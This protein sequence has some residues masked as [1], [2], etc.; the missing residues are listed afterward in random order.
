M[1]YKQ[2]RK[3]KKEEGKYKQIN[4]SAPSKWR[5]PAGVLGIILL[6]LVGLGYAMPA[7]WNASVGQTGLTFAQEPFRLG[8]DLL[9][10]THLVY[11]ADLSEIPE[12]ERRDSLR[13][14][15]D[16]IERRVNAFGVA[17]PLVQ[18]VGDD[19]IIV[20]LAGISDVNEAINQIG[21]TPIL[22]FKR[23]ADG[24]T[25]GSTV[26]LSEVVVETDED[27]NT[28]ITSAEDGEPVELDLAA[29]A[30]EQA[31]QQWENTELGGAQLKRAGVEFDHNTGAPFVTLTFDADG[32]ELFGQLTEEYVGRQVA[33]FLDG[34]VISAP[35]VQQPIYGGEAVITGSG[36]LEEARTLALS[37][38]HI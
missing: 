18:P 29:L 13:G 36:D 12:T 9:G 21:E 23:P 30:A 19:R 24:A 15:R 17:E 8:L 35:V 16:V 4:A 20:E 27:G 32:G 1:A 11:E 6:T 26:D 25:D 31:Q 33:I 10:G 2:Y 22:E 7:Q 38:I 3:Q 28:V 34:Q 5:L 37:L 14:V